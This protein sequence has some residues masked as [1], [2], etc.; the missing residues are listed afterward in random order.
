MARHVQLLEAA[1][2]LQ[3][4]WVPGRRR[5]GWGIIVQMASGLRLRRVACAFAAAALLTS[6]V[7]LGGCSSTIDHIP[8]AIGGL[9]EGVPARPAEPP[10]YPAVHDM[11]PPRSSTPLTEAE[12]KLLKDDLIANRNRAIQQGTEATSTVSTEATGSAGRP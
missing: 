3:P 8:T 4:E 6:A 12:K 9:P 11:P 10:P 5:E 1:A 7:M 2:L